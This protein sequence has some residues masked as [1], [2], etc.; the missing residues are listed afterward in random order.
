MLSVELP[1]PLSSTVCGLFVAFVLI[2]YVALCNP[3]EVGVKVKTKLQLACAAKVPL[4]VGH[5]VAGD[6]AKAVPEVRTSEWMVSV[7]AS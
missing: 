5:V 4:G 7:P 2:V 6:T 1:V 3:A